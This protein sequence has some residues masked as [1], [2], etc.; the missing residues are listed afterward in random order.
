[1]D[2]KKRSLLR[3]DSH[4][5]VCFLLYSHAKLFCFGFAHVYNHR[6]DIVQRYSGSCFR[7]YCQEFCSKYRLLCDFMCSFG[8]NVTVLYCKWTKK[9]WK[10]IICFPS[11][12]QVHSKHSAPLDG[13]TSAMTSSSLLFFWQNVSKLLQTPGIHPQLKWKFIQT[14]KWFCLFF[15]VG[16]SAMSF[17]FFEAKNFVAALHTPVYVGIW[18]RTTRTLV[19]CAW[20]IY[21]WDKWNITKIGLGNSKFSLLESDLLP[22]AFL[23]FRVYL[24]TRS[25]SCSIGEMI[26]WYFWHTLEQVSRFLFESLISKKKRKAYLE[27][28][29][30]TILFRKESSQSLAPSLSLST[31]GFLLLPS[32]NAKKL[33]RE[34]RLESFV[35][36]K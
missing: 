4:R 18:P 12:C 7:L 33:L 32:K 22:C 29:W 1:M 31:A 35:A 23:C 6:T 36:C 3:R 5:V 19:F 14:H 17:L 13:F 20:R 26:L 8:R 21:H 34:V 9:K 25:F 11:R 15:S 10:G 24:L 28:G 2:C 16:K 30:R 27:I